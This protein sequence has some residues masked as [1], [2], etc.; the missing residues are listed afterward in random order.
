V[1]L[2]L[3]AGAVS[4]IVAVRHL[5]PIVPGPLVALIAA[6]AVSQAIGYDGKTVGP[7]TVALMPSLSAAS[8]GSIPS[9][10]LPAVLIALVGFAEPATIARR[11]AT[12]DRE[13]WDPDREFVS[14][15]LANLVAALSGA[16]PV[17]GSFSRTALARLAGAKTRW[18]TAFSSLAILGMVPFLSL[19]E[20]L[21]ISVLGVIVIA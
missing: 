21:P 12:L 3:G 19:V 11:Y 13:R 17:G 5:N 1:A 6:T 20:P 14:Q 7:T 10:V 15:G 9:L 4:L 2:L 8:I 16:F 18:A